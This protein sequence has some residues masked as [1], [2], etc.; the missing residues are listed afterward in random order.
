MSEFAILEPHPRG[1]FRPV[2]VALR[3][4]AGAVVPRSRAMR[5]V[6]SCVVRGLAVERRGGAVGQ[7]TRVVAWSEW[8]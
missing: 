4:A 1:A 7:V 5:S 3:A 6:G 2:A 8:V